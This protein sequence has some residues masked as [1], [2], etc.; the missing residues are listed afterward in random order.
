M[1]NAEAVASQLA[2]EFLR[3]GKFTAAQGPVEVRDLA[4]SGAAAASIEG[5]DVL[6]FTGAPTDGASEGFGGIAVQSV[7]Y[8]EGAKSPRVHVYLTRGSQRLIRS[9]PAEVRGIPIRAHRMGAV[10]VRPDAAQTSTNQGHLF[11]RDNRIACGSSCGPTS[12]NCTGTLGALI[13]KNRSSQIYLLSNNHVFAGCNHVPMG[14]PILSPS[15]ADGRPTIRAPGEIGR[16]ELIHE[17]RSG[18]PNFVNPCEAD[19]ALARATNDAILSSWQGDDVN[20][21]DTPGNMS[22]PSTS[23]RVKKF[24]RTTGLTFGEIEAK[25]VA[26]MPVDYLAKHFR[27]VIWFSNVWTVRGVSGVFALAGD[28]GSLVVTEDSS[29][30]VGVVFAANRSGEYGWIIPMP[31]VAASFGGVRLVSGHGV[32]A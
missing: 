25:V 1:T 32:G 12:E 6:G 17:L 29:K 26:P 8:E 27:G 9:L 3:D 30:A 22:S 16:H 31:S 28:S 5:F 14:Q 13:R 2:Y 19:L 7:G 24:G 18:N 23:V 20:G 10:N 21:Y 11:E 4:V 15:T